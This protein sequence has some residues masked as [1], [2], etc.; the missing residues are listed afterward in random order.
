MKKAAVIGGHGKV[1]GYLVPMLASRGYHMINISRGKT[2]LLVENSAWDDVEQ[3]SLDRNAPGFE[4]KIRA[5]G[6]DV[7]VD[8][9]C[10]EE[11]AMLRLAEALDGNVSHYLVCGSVWMHGYGSA[12][13]YTEEECREPMEEYGIQKGRMHQSIARLYDEKQFPG[14]AVHPGHIVCPGDVPINPQGAK[15]LD[16]F[17]ALQAGKQLYLPNL[18]LETLHHVHAEDVA[19]VFLA[20]ITKGAAAF[21]E[22]FHA[23]SPRA[24]T[25]RGYAEEVASW[26]GK[27]A[28][29]AFEPYD[30]WK[31]RMSEVDAAATW[32]HISH[33][34]SASM[35]KAKALLGF[36]PRHTSYEAIRECVVSFGLV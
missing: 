13:P 26:Y 14:T 19:G 27:K 35:Q 4:E 29:L 25:L 9:I 20:A 3:V 21:G 33:S 18:G 6:A 32:S 1:G 11:A 28:D 23:V 10:F 36:E 8:M 34:P 22:G 17:R 30:Q 15:S 2:G 16:A 5:L 24:V 31:N 12:V 7:V